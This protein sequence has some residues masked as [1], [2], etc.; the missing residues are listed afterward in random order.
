[1]AGRSVRAPARQHPARARRFCARRHSARRARAPPERQPVACVSGSCGRTHA[2]ARMCRG[3]VAYVRARAHSP[4]SVVRRQCA[5]ST[6]ERRRLCGPVRAR[7]PPPPVALGPPGGTLS[8]GALR[9][10]FRTQADAF[11][12]RAS[13]SQNRPVVAESGP[14]VPKFRAASTSIGQCG[15]ESTKTL[16]MSTDLGPAKFGQGCRS[17]PAN[18]QKYLR[19]D[20]RQF[21]K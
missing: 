20:S 21:P 10:F 2:R 5:S 4:E 13:S 12:H 18:V 3:K 1:M 16:K 9:T 14:Q 15:P 19:S 17:G 7:L 8:R 11:K 6:A